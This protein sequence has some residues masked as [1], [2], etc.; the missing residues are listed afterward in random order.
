[1]SRKHRPPLSKAELEVAGVVWRLGG[2]TVR[3]VLEALPEHRQSEVEY[4]TVQTYLRRL[5]AKGYLKGKKQGRSTFYKARVGQ[6]RVIRE[7]VSDFITRLFGGDPLPLL[8]HL[9]SEQG[10]SP[11]EIRRVR[12]MIDEKE[13]ERD[14]PDQQ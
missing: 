4:K 10:L 6:D 12:E 11:R 5:E 14:E 3:E 13:G 8:E 9:I 2:G 7:N 1:M